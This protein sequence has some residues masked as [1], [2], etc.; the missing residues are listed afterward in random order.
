MNRRSFVQRISAGIVAAMVAVG[1]P[2]KAVTAIVGVEA[3]SDAA[4]RALFYEWQKYLNT[5]PRGRYPYTAYIGPELM[6]IIE[7]EWNSF[8]THPAPHDWR[9]DLST[10]DIFYFRSMRLE[11]YNADGHAWAFKFK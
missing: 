2:A 11:L 1:F 9:A 3:A 5:L 6:K 10:A 8:Y 7:A 4:T